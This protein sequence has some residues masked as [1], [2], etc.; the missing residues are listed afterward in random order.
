[1]SIEGLYF[2]IHR[3]SDS[4]IRE[5]GFWKVPIERY[6]YIPEN[7]MRTILIHLLG[8]WSLWVPLAAAG[9][10]ATRIEAMRFVREGDNFLR[11]GN[12]EQALVSYSNAIAADQGYADAYMK[13]SSLNEIV[14][15]YSEAMV[16]YDTA[17]RLNPYSVAIFDQRR[18]LSM[19]ATNYKGALHGV[20]SGNGHA[21]EDEPFLDHRVD[22]FIEMGMYAEAIQDID[23]LLA[24]GYNEQYELEKKALVFLL[25][26]D[27][28]NSRATAQDILTR[29]PHS[30]LA[31]DVLGVT[32]LRQ[33]RPDEAIESFSQSI[34]INPRFPLSWFNR[35]IAYRMK[36]MT[37][38]AL[39]DLNYALQLGQEATSAYFMRALLY[40]EDG[41]YEKALKDYDRVISRD[42][43]HTDALYNRSFTHK[44]LGDYH[45]ALKDAETILQLDPNSAD[46][47]NLQGNV[48]VLFG[49]YYDAIDSFSRAISF[50]PT[51]AEA[52][53]N[54]GIAHLLLY[55][56]TQAC[57]DLKTGKQHGYD[58]AGIMLEA[59]CGR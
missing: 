1:M 25:L 27:Y 28:T 9:Q 38:R 46:Y 12:W 21:P 51:F 2:E 17:V 37:P 35:A 55:S 34:Q 43:S 48:Q 54:R 45:S 15:R 24:A 31:H 3:N 41:E 32:S 8:F 18:R 36:G 59:F 39:S 16:D 13:R 52:F 19:L 53:Y 29:Y 50:N 26:G 4:S 56:A 49:N 44:L 23:T 58:R 40:K 47:W 30:F 33:D 7:M 22:D 20:G 10:S 5:R 6:N 42:D 57:Q 11:I 14:G